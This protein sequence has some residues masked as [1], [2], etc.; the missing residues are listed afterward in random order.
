MLKELKRFTALFRALQS[1]PKSMADPSNST[2]QRSY[3][4]PGGG[5]G[6]RRGLGLWWPQSHQGPPT[7]TDST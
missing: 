5:G 6:G 3:L 7:N 1:F 4:E 2:V